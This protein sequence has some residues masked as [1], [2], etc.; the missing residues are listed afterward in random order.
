MS[1]PDWN[2]ADFNGVSLLQIAR[3]HRPRLPADLAT[4]VDDAI[5]HACRSIQKRNVGPGYTNIAIM[6]T[7]VT[8]VAGELLDL[9]EFRAYGLERLRRFSDHTAAN[10]TFEEYNS[11]TYTIVA[12]HELSRLQAHV[13]DPDARALIEPL[14]RH[15]WEQLAHHFHAPTRQWA[16]PHSRAYSSLVAPGT[17]ALIQRGTAGRIDFGLDAPDR[18]EYRLPVAC[19]ADLEPHFRALS[20]PRTVTQTFIKRSQTVGTTYLHPQYALGTINR[21][22]MWNQRRPLLLHYGTATRPG[23]LQLRFLKNGYDFS[24]ALFTSAQREGLVVGAVTLFTNGGDTHLSLDKVKNARIQARDLR[25][26]FE[27]GGPAAA[28]VRITPS[29]GPHAT[30]AAIDAAGL[31]ISI[32]LL[33]ARLDARDATFT[34]GGDSQLRWLELILYAGDDRQ[35]DLAALEEA[36]VGFVLS[37]GSPAPPASVRVADGKMALACGELSVTVAS[38]PAAR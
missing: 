6:G 21:G 2:W 4:A 18:E 19:P 27:F 9:P 38:R 17:L 1:P 10:G 11:P 8:L 12:L 30:A 32:E 37:A 22:D 29:P 3:D 13:R 14:V 28:A 36:V 25:L 34:A 35:F 33:R 26:R 15:A 7:Y 24:S 16:G 23:Y 5:R 20:A 31:P